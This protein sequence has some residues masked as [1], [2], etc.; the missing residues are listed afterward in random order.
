MHAGDD[1]RGDSP[2]AHNDVIALSN[3]FL[4]TVNGESLGD[5][6]PSVEGSDA[7]SLDEYVPTSTPA[8]T[9]ARQLQAHTVG[10]R[11]GEEVQEGRTRAQTR[12]LNQE[13]AADLIGVFGSDKGDK[14]IHGLLA[15][16]GDTCKLGELL[17]CVV[18]EMES[19]PVSY[20]ATCSSEFSDEWMELMENEFD[21]IEAAETLEEVNEIPEG[22]NI[23]NVKELYQ[24]KGDSC[25]MV[26]RDKARIVATEYRQVEESRILRDVRP[27][28][29]CYV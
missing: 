15:V 8:R 11:D 24:W 12:T 17:N 19:E 3:D 10:P 4:S 7:S 9:T 21:G 28:G 2:Q 23:V 14:V 18:G 27:H 26:E 13:A 29:I 25:V 22:C 20:S 16:H 6:I 5:A 1:V